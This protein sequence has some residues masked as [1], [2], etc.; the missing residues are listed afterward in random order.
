MNNLKVAAAVAL[1]LGGSTAAQSALASPTAAQ[2]AAAT[3]TLYIAGSSAAQPSFATALANDLFDSNGETTIAAPAVAG[4]ANGNFKAYC[5]AAKTGNGAGITAGTIVTVYYRGEGGSVVGALPVFSGKKIKFLD[6]T[7]TGCAVTNPSVTG[8]SVN[9]GTTDGW[10][11]CVTTHAVEMGVTDLEPGQF[12]TPNY[13]TAYSAS[14]FGSAT[15]AQLAGL[16]KTPLF[17]QVFGLFVNTSGFNGGTTT[18]IAVDLSRETAAAILSGNYSDWSAVPTASGG[19]VSTTSQAITVVNREA[20]SGTRTGASIYFLGT[21]CVTFPGALQD[22]AP[23]SDGYATGDVLATAG[24]TP[25]AITYASIDNAG[26]ANL[27]TVSLA[28]VAPSNLAATEGKYDW[29]FEATAQLGTITSPN[30]TA[31]YNWLV[32]GELANVASAPHALDILAIPGVGT[33]VGAVPVT[34]STV[35][36]VTIYINPFSKNGNSCSIPAPTNF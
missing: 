14:V 19:V 2:C 24:A 25:G 28:G 11:G 23:L 6:L 21:N 22:L 30:G 32:S 10:S 27:T 4:S 18:G 7:G 36:G 34:S 12:H 1:A 16:T 35:G 29:W 33:N 17:Q 5:G 9:V 13:P 20:G 31:I 8:L 26:K 15:Q 3:S